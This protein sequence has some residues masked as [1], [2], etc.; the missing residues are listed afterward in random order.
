MEIDNH[1]GIQLKTTENQEA[2]PKMN[3]VLAIELIG[4]FFRNKVSSRIL[5]LAGRNM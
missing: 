1:D 5:Y 4:E 3:T 2:M